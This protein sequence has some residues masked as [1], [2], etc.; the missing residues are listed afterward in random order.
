MGRRLHH[1]FE[2]GMDRERWKR[3]SAQRNPDLEKQKPDHPRNGDA[4][5]RNRA[6]VGLLLAWE[7]LKAVTDTVV[8]TFF[9]TRSLIDESAAATLPVPEASKR[10]NDRK[11][12]PRGDV[13]SHERGG[14]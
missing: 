11:L 8:A 2:H 5:T 3:M 1:R 13:Q 14:S 10:A 4:Q 7:S 12:D 9:G 6:I